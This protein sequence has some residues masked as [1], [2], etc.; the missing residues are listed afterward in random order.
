MKAAVY[1]GEG[2]PLI[3]ESLPDPEPGPDDV[4]IEVHRCGIC[5]TDLHMTEGHD[6]QF[7]AGCVPG[8]E[9]SGEVVAVGA[10]VTTLKTGDLITALPSMGCGHCVACHQGN[11]SLCR[12]APGV[13]GGFAELLKVPVAS[14]IKLPGTLS[15]AD[16]AL[17]EPMAIGLYAV[18]LS[19]IQPGDRVLVLG[20]GSVAL[21]AI[22]WAKRLGA[23]HIV[24][25]SRSS[26]RRAL[27]LEMGADAF[28]YYGDNEIGEVAEALGGP[29]DIVYE[30]VGNPGF[31]MKGIQHV[32]TL[33][34]VVSMGFCTAPDQ[35]VPALAGF[36]GV[37]LLFPV[38]YS[39]KDFQYVADVMDAG[40]VDP[41]ILIT[42]VVPLDDLQATL[43]YLR[44]VNEETKV[45]VT[46]LR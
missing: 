37:S 26:R 29:P 35:I 33:G 44:G 16:G 36:K 45:H 41:K 22:Y 46:P 1:P 34:Q 19:R 13:M 2:K 10:K 43:E 39:L 42:S 15:A 25:M 23:G 12:N 24:A 9:Y 14:A 17:V 18:R 30:C 8:H 3:L 28:I 5:G 27:A 32:R 7:P 11:I 6:W 20:A 31:V 21:C 40:H 4:V 38:G